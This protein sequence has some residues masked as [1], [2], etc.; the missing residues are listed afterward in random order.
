MGLFQF[1]RMPFGLCGTPS[2]FQRLMDVVMR[3]LPFVTTYIDDVLIHSA[4]EELHKSHLEQTFQRLREAGLTLRG[5]KC[6]IGMAQVTYLGHTFSREGM[7]PDSSKVDAV[8]NWPQPKDEAE[9]R[10]FLGLASY[11]RKYIDKFADMA[12][13]LYQLTQKDTPFQWTKESEESFQRLKACLTEAPVL[14]YP[15]F[16]K[17]AST[18]VLQTDASNVGLGAVLEQ[19][20]RVIGYASRTLTKAEANYSV[21]QRECLAIVWAMKQFRH[22][23]LGRTFQLMTDHAPLQWLAEQKMEGLLC[24]WALAIQEFSFGIVYRKGT[25]NGNADALSRRREPESETLHAALT[26]VYS[27]FTAEEIRQSTET[28]GHNPATVQC[29]PV[30]ASPSTQKLEMTT[31]ETICPALVTACYSG[32]YCVQ[33]VPARPYI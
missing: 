20:Q 18:M 33:E 5:S 11:Y 31:N 1:T 14:A 27:G 26:T 16:R 2:T 15:S 19:D 13:P 8:V 3:G 22:Y 12:A 28:G 24:H 25:A 10:Q 30:Q 9:V 6:Q 17:Q 29:T 7:S 4:N 23:L 21:I 32:W